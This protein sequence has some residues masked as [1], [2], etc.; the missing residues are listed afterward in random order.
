MAGGSWGGGNIPGRLWSDYAYPGTDEFKYWATR[1][2]K[3]M[4]LAFMWE[5]VQP[6][7]KGYFSAQD[8]AEIDRCVAAAVA[9]GQTIILD[10]HNYGKRADQP[11]GHF[12]DKTELGNL[13]WKLSDR[14]KANTNVVYGLNNEPAN[15]S[16]SDWKA[17]VIESITAIRTNTQTALIS[18]AWGSWDGAHDFITAG[19]P[20]TF[21]GITDANIIL[22]VHQYLDHDF[23]GSNLQEYVA[24]SGATV[25]KPV[26]DWARSKKIRVLVGEFGFALPAGLTEST[27]ML[28]HMQDNSDVYWGWTF[29]KSGPIGWGGDAFSIQ[30]EN[31]T[32]APQIA[33]LKK[34]MA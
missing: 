26:T 4:R 10:C 29:W 22:E 24:G 21:D 30:P 25:L 8:I 27:A 32:D 15:L 28:Q 16:L 19:G 11:A 5:R 33:V 3:L 14:Y 13:W 2:F 34:F 9:N 7:V 12:G 23:S 1:G 18:V 31:N 6:K 17:Q 20:A